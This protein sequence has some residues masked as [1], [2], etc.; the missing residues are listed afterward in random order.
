M[1]SVLT[2]GP[3]G[4]RTAPAR[5]IPAEDATV[6]AREDI[7]PT[8]ARFVIRPD[9][10]MPAFRPGQYVSVGL[11]VDGRLVRRPYSTAAHPRTADAHELLVRH[12]AGGSLTPHLWRCSAGDRVHLGGPKGLFTLDPDDRRPHLLVAS[13]TGIAPFVS[14]LREITERQAPPRTVVVHG[15]S[16]ATDLAYRD[17][18]AGWE[19][20]GALRYLPTVSRPHDPASAGW[21]GRTGRTE[22]AL[23]DAFVA[24]GPGAA[25]A[26]VCGNP[27][28][29]VSATRILHGLGVSDVRSESFW[30]TSAAAV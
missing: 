23:A 24:L 2:A 12:V 22:A 18:L 9:G 21:A 4:T 8:I 1:T 17:L 25:V 6:V 27:G 5:S 26:Y 13:G 20:A 30:E 15:V 3:R 7:S 29:V 28:M 11:Q 10:P 16:R 14:M 19:T